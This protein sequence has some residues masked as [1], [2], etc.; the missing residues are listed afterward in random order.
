MAVMEDQ[1][2]VHVG[3]ANVLLAERVIASMLRVL[4]PDEVA[5]SD[6][7]EMWQAFDGI[8]RLGANA[9]TLLAA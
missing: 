2:R 7:T 6:V 8:E 9:K 1:A 4:E 5:F 3:L